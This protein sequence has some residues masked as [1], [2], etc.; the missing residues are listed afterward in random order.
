MKILTKTNLSY[1]PLLLVVTAIFF[2]A[3]C[4]KDAFNEKDA[5]AAQTTFLQMKQDHEIKLEQLKQTGAT[6]LAQ[7]QYSFGIQTKAAELRL[8][9]S[10]TRV[11]QR[12]IDSL[13]RVNTRYN[14]SID[15]SNSSKRD[16]VVMVRD[17]VTLQ[18]VAGA[19]VTIPTKINTVLQ[20]NTDANGMATFAAAGNANV[21]NPASALV[22]KTGYGSGSIIH[23]ITGSGTVA[24]SANIT[25]WNQANSR[26][27]IRGNVSIQTNFVNPTPEVASGK[28]INLFAL[29]TVNGGSQRFDWSALTDANGDYSISVPDLPGGASFNLSHNVFDTVARLAVNRVLPGTDSIPSLKLIPASYY[30]GVRSTGTAGLIM[31]ASS[32]SVAVPTFVNR[33]H[34]VT[35]ADSN[36]RA[37]YF[38]N[39]TFN[40]TTVNG[41]LTAFVTAGT[42]VSS[43]GTYDINGNSTGTAYTSRF[44]GTSNSA[45][46]SLPARFVDI[47][48]N[49]DGLWPRNPKLNFY[50]SAGNV[51]PSAS[52]KFITFKASETTATNPAITTFN[53]ITGKTTGQGATFGYDPLSWGLVNPSIATTLNTSVQN[54]A[55]VGASS[56]TPSTYNATSTAAVT[57]ITASVGQTVVLNLSFGTGQLKVAVQ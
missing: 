25:I 17:V 10:L 30:L 12:Y 37:F 48:Y 23:G 56:I 34:A 4:K 24:G 38:K 15:R 40:S 19:T 57:A 6:A 54:R 52:Q 20:A 32:T 7:L 31:Q 51:S 53:L 36:N 28:L 29:V 45:V 16:I 5:L 49:E 26:N 18:P 13:T 50:V 46:D 8:Q 33:Y 11:Y 1:L 14:D 9:D 3:S 35:P 27:T 22:T 41:V 47:L 42:S 43:A 2:A 44:A 21:A 55:I 39:M